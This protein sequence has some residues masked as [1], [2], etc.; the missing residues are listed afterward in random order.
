M[1]NTLAVE[2]V[3]PE[4][5]LYSGTAT[6]V[7]TR[8]LGGG[9]IAFMAGHQPFLAALADGTTKLYLEGGR[10]ETISVHGGFVSVDGKRVTIL[11]DAAEMPAH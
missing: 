5:V 4:A 6:M 2:V 10:V 1:A 3:S 9:D 7:V 11:S 8:T